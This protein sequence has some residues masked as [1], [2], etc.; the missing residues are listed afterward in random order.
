MVRS[1][2]LICEHVTSTGAATHYT[3]PAGHR[4]IVKLWTVFNNSGA[5]A[6]VT[7]YIETAA[8]VDVGVANAAALAAG[9]SLAAPTQ[10]V[11]NAGDK[12]GMF[13]TSSGLDLVAAGAEL[14]L[15]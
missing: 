10:I 9:S 6:A 4:T 15:P 3:A 12:L 13:S 14:E 8:A 7:L 11:L 2:Q 1:T 5:A